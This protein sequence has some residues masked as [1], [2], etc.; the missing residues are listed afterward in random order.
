MTDDTGGAT[1]TDDMSR[2]GD[3]DWGRAWIASFEAQAYRHQCGPG[4]GAVG[5]L[6]FAGSPSP[7]P[8]PGTAP[9]SAMGHEVES[10]DRLSMCLCRRISEGLLSSRDACRVR[11][12]CRSS[13]SRDVCR[14]SESRD[15]CQSSESADGGGDGSILGHSEGPIHPTRDP[16][17]IEVDEKRVSELPLAPGDACKGTHADSRDRSG[18]ETTTEHESGCLR[19]RRDDLLLEGIDFHCCRDMIPFVLSRCAGTL[20]RALESQ[21]EAALTQSG[22]TSTTSTSTSTSTSDDTVVGATQGPTWCGDVDGAGKPQSGP[23]LS[24][25]ALE[26]LVREAVWLYRSSTNNHKFLWSGRLIAEGRE[27]VAMTHEAEVKIDLDNK[28]RLAPVW[29]VISSAVKSFAMSKLA[30]ISSV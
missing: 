19:L 15:A 18:N 26:R 5:S 29:G 22:V 24:D 13:E 28:R 23:G 17:L 10:F 3:D 16:E 14:S 25:E 8:S 6:E 20:R 27:A 1:T 21:S 11:D 9:S 7:S 2:S 30:K 12:A 4:L